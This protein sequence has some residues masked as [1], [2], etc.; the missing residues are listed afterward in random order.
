MTI[1]EK[2]IENK[3]KELSILERLTPVKELEKSGLL[4]TSAYS[5]SSSIADKSKTGIIA[6]FKRKSPSKGIINSSFASGRGC[7]RLFQ[8]RSIR[9]FNSDRHTVFWRFGF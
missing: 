5:L 3:K 9:C 2:I 1:L 7:F 6:E 4:Q 8:G